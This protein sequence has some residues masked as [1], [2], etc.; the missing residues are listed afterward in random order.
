MATPKRLPV[1]ESLSELKALHRS[2][3][4]HLKARVQ[5]LLLIKK[6]LHHSKAALG[7][8]LGIHY[9]TIQDW[10]KAYETGGLTALLPYKRGSGRHR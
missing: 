7:Q 9:T 6:D 8:A 5:M 1:Q 3:A 2:S 10:K 4:A